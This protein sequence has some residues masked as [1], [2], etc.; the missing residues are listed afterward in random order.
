VHVERDEFEAKFWLRPVRLEGSYGFGR[1]EITRIE[2]SGH[3]ERRDFAEG[4]G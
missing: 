3:R 2:G 4:M 1:R